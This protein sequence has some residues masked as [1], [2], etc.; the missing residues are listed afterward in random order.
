MPE[1]SELG[2]TV[3]DRVGSLGTGGWISLKDEKPASVGNNKFNRFK[4]T[5]ASMT[6]CVKF[7]HNKDNECMTLMEYKHM[8]PIFLLV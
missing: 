1:S 5:V 6:N 2:D 8:P 7:K 3:E 4:F